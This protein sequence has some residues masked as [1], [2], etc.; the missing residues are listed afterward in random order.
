MSSL[1]YFGTILG[2]D[3]EE[4]SQINFRT[5]AATICIDFKGEVILTHNNNNNNNNN[6]Y[7]KEH[8]SKS[9]YKVFFGYIFFL[10]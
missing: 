8:F 2:T 6:Y 1:L 5:Y 3:R 4:M 10:Y 7:N 9:I